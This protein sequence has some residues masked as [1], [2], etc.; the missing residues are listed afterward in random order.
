[1]RVPP[2]PTMSRVLRL[3]A[4]GLASLAGRTIDEIEDIKIAVSEVMIALVEHGEGQPVEIQLIAD[5]ASFTVRGRTAVTTFD[6]NHPDLVLCRTV[7]AGVGAEHGIEVIE[8]FAEIWA[9][10][11]G[12]GGS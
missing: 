6:V 10:V 12:S 7:L 11:D 5:P 8:G 3:A 1:M 4:S 9:S 2:E